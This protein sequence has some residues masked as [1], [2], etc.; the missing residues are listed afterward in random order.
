[1]ITL[2]GTSHLYGKTVYLQVHDYFFHQASRFL[3][4]GSDTSSLE[5]AS[6]RIQT[7]PF[8]LQAPIL[9]FSFVLV[10]AKVDIRLP[11]EIQNRTL[12]DKLRR[13]DICGSITLV[14]AVGCL[15]LG[16]D[17]KTSEDLGWTHPLFLL[18]LCSS[19]FFAFTF[20]IT[21]KYFAPYP[22][23]PLQL[24]TQRTPLSVSLSN[25]L[26]SMGVFSMVSLKEEVNSLMSDRYR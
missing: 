2:G 4:A 18:L 17:L 6:I 5:S 8:P 10:A 23:M 1:M 7:L 14:G 19:I 22:V 25:L 3:H 13:I 20:V 12:R 16:F 24:V 15:L 26:L 21:E 11:D 9:I